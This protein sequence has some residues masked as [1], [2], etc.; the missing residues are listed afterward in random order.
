VRRSGRDP[1][2]LDEVFAHLPADA[3]LGQPLRA[4]TALGH[5]HLHVNDLDASMRFY[6]DGLG[7][8]QQ[9][10]APGLGMADVTVDGWGPHLVAFNT[11]HG[12]NAPRPPADAAG[13]RWFTYGLPSAA[14]RDAAVARLE[15]QGV[16]IGRDGGEI[17][18]HDPAGN[19]L[20]LT[21]REGRRA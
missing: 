10:L 9:M 13:L 6:R 1:L 21:V 7:L 19:E 3:D 8:E 14:E 4:G 11:W 12:A 16:E 20:L 2:D 5:I 17:R 15:A 18:V